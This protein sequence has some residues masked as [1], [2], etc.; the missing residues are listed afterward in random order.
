LARA[1]QNGKGCP[2]RIG[3]LQ[4]AFFNGLGYSTWENVVS[5]L[6]RASLLS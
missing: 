5:Q 2:N 3:Q 6:H 1:S 4:V